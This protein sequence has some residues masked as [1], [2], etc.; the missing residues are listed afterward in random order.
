MPLLS[1]LLAEL[2]LLC[3]DPSKLRISAEIYDALMAKAEVCCKDG[4]AKDE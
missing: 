4:E 3:A 1:H 2:E